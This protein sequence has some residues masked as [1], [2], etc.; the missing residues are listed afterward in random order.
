MAGRRRGA[1]RMV[2]AVS[3]S[4]SSPMTGKSQQKANA[5]LKP[6]GPWNLPSGFL[7]NTQCP[8]IQRLWDPLLMFS[9]RK[10][11]LG[12]RTGQ[13]TKGPY[14]WAHCLCLT[15]ALRY[16]KELYDSR[17]QEHMWPFFPIYRRPVPIWSNL[18]YSFYS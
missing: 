3:I 6:F 11:L 10:A 2:L 4:F 1:L 17:V 5:N 14:C 13:L 15:E 7:A 18:Q 8:H 12:L 9:S 16:W